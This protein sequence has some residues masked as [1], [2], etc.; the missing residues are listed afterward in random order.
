MKV[1]AKDWHEKHV[2]LIDD[3]PGEERTLNVEGGHSRKILFKGDL[4]IKI[5]FH[6]I[7][8]Q[9]W[10]QS[11]NELKVW[12]SLRDEDRKHF[13]EVV[14][15]GKVHGIDWS[16]VAQRFMN[17]EKPWD[18]NHV[19]ADIQ[20]LVDTLK[21]RYALRD[22]HGNYCG[23]NWGMVNGVPVIYDYGSVEY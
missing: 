11:A 6:G 19:P 16:W 15:G 18:Y 17:F 7:G 12:K 23:R 2:I 9:I 3:E 10:D 13:A 14:D 5:T 22:L 20:I 4:V 21:E 1:S 8:S